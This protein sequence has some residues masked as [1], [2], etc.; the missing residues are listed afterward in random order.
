MKKTIQDLYFGNVLPNEREVH[1][2]SDYRMAS[3]EAEAARDEFEKQLTDAQKA[4][5]NDYVD[6]HNFASMYLEFTAFLEGFR[7]ASRLLVE[8]LVPKDEE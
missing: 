5:F 6:K 8:A 1:K 2:N 4:L 7:L 3:K